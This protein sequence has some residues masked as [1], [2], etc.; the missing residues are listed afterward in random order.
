MR[1]DGTP[2]DLPEIQVLFEQGGTRARF[3]PDGSGIIYMQGRT[4]LQDFH[5]LDL[6]SMQSRRLTRLEDPAEMRTFD[7]T[8]DGSEIVFDRLRRNSDVV[9]IELAGTAAAD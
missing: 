1:D 8:P 6:T 2:V 9:L 5:L 3:L 4:L 7:V